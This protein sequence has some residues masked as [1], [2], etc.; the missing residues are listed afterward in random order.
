MTVHVALLRAVNLGSHG[1]VPM[2]DLRAWC[3]DLG[4]TDVATYLQSGNVAFIAEGA[5]DGDEATVAARLGD[6]IEAGC[7]VRTPVLVRGPAEL[8]DVVAGNPFADEVAAGDPKFV[9][10]AFL[11]E[12]PAADRITAVDPDRSPGDRC[13]VQGRHAYL[14]YPN[15]SGR[16]KLTN[17]YLERTLG[18]VSTARNWNTV[19]ALEALA[20][21][22][23]HP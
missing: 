11:S 15:G 6:R 16:S 10:V 2:A 1:K 22:R 23:A 12:A 20:A 3:A 13:V 14:H 4:F 9:H 18:V 19:L 5:A 21:E 7:G 17:D 8:A